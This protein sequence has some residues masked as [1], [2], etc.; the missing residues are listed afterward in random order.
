MTIKKKLTLS[1]QT[2][3]VLSADALRGVA[4]AIS[5]DPVRCNKSA[6]V[7]CIGVPRGPVVIGR[8]WQR[9]I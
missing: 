7:A 6:L 4:G 1:S 3:R 2:L 8:G 9:E 5:G